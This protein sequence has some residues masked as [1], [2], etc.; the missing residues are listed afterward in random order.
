MEKRIEKEFFGLL[1]IDGI[2]TANFEKLDYNTIIFNADKERERLDFNNGIIIGGKPAKTKY[3]EVLRMV[4]EAISRR[5]IPDSVDE[6][7]LA[8]S[9]A[10]VIRDYVEWYVD[11]LDYT[12]LDPVNDRDYIKTL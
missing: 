4:R 9:M 11:I 12:H 10:S 5:E 6:D 8:I 2:I 7:K 1:D 3:K